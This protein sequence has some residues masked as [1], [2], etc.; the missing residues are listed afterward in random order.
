MLN[1]TNAAK[2]VVCILLAALL[3]GSL[4]AQKTVT[5]K[6]TGPDGKPIFGA[7]VAVKGTVIATS[8]ATDGSYSIVMPSGSKT[9]IFSSVGFE[10]SE[11]T[12]KD[13]GTVDAVMKLQTTS[14]NEVVVTGYSA[15]RKKDITGAVSVVNINEL[16][17]QPVGTGEEALAGT[18]IRD[19]RY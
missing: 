1:K 17:Q 16:K 10:L 4:L 19:K 8:T 18:C 12:V 2:A 7:T 11:S 15:Q 6:V 3:S 5:G 13:A 14:L 9:L